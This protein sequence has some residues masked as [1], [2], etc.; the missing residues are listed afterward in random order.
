MCYAQSVKYVAHFVHEMGKYVAHFVK[1]DVC[2][3]H[4]MAIRVPIS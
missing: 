2:Q 3:F 1:W 4:E